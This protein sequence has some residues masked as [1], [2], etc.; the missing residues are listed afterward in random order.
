MNHYP[1]HI[2]YLLA[3]FEKEMANFGQRKGVAKDIYQIFITQQALIKALLDERYPTP[4][5]EPQ[6]YYNVFL[7]PEHYTTFN[8]WYYSNKREADY[9]DK[10]TIISING[11]LWMKNNNDNESTDWEVFSGINNILRFDYE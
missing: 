7:V 3:T 2:Q 10:T 1:Q 5:E 8:E 4:K 9:Q 6:G 11:E